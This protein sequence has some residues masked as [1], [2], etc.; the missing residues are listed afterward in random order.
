M[1]VTARNLYNLYRN[2]KSVYDAYQGWNKKR[3]RSIDQMPVRSATYPAKRKSKQVVAVSTN[4]GSGHVG[5]AVLHKA[6]KRSHSHIGRKRKVGKTK[7]LS[8]I[9][10]APVASFDDWAHYLLT[11]QT[12]QL[13]VI[14]FVICPARTLTVSSWTQAQQSMITDFRT[15]ELNDVGVSF[16]PGIFDPPPVVGSIYNKATGALVPNIRAAGLDI[17]V[18][19]ESMQQISDEE[20]LNYQILHEDFF[21]VNTTDVPIMVRFEEYLCN[22]TSDISLQVRAQNLYAGQQYFEPQAGA[23]ADVQN[24]ISFSL[25]KVPSLNTWWKK[26]SFHEEF[27]QPG[28]EMKRRFAYTIR[29]NQ[30]KFKN[31][32][33]TGLLFPNYVKGI[34]RVV[35]VSIRGS[36]GASPTDNLANFTVAQIGIA[37]HRFIK[38]FRSLVGGQVKKQYNVSQVV[39]NH[40]TTNIANVQAVADLQVA[41][42]GATKNFAAGTVI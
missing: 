24:E 12:N 11:A 38:G 5:G 6:Y 18:G 1:P 37:R 9:L 33:P 25:S 29:F 19:L 32:D 41:G 3:K 40:L 30:Q 36:L 31:M 16:Q 8:K 10:K 17:N 28:A 39:V 42:G 26:V 23:V 22:T 21:Y 7:K 14:D 2:G 35:R 4:P 15:G 20:I 13:K 27:I 34:T